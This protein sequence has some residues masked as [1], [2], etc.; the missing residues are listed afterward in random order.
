[1]SKASIFA[2][3]LLAT[4][5]ATPITPTYAAEPPVQP[6]NNDIIS[7]KITQTVVDIAGALH[8]GRLLNPANNDLTNG[9]LVWVGHQSVIEC[10]QANGYS[11]EGIDG[12]FGPCYPDSQ[13]Q[14][15]GAGTQ[16]VPMKSAADCAMKATIGAR[17]IQ[18]TIIP[19]LQNAGAS[20]V[21]FPSFRGFGIAGI[22]SE[23]PFTESFVGWLGGHFIF[24]PPVYESLSSIHC[25]YLVNECDGP[26]SC[27]IYHR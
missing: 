19:S 1:M 14:P 24:G 3:C 7:D 9:P 13:Y 26:C 10:S 21:A 17:A 6:F 12:A 18:N 11:S 22:C 16:I 23:G 20:G 5:A 8:L 25:A 4:T 15:F 27:G 2:L